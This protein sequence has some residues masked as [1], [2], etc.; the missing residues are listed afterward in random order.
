MKTIRLM[1]WNVNGLRAVHRKKALDWFLDEKP[2]ILCLQETKAAANQIPD[3][4]KNIDGYH[5]Y[6]VSAEKKGYSGVALYS[7]REPKKLSS[8]FGIEKFD[9]EGRIIIAEYDKFILFNIYYPNGKQ[10]KERLH[11][12]MEFY[13]TFLEIADRMKNGGKNLVICGDVNTAHK[14]I[15]LARPKEN[16]KVSGFLPEERAWMDKFVEHGYHDTFRMF[17]REPEQY[18]WWDMITRARERNVG[19]RIDYF[20]VSDSLKKKVRKAFIRPEIMG[21]DHCP[22]GIDLSL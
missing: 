7:R 5:T 13:D 12:K 3:E 6:F 16:E 8:G 14:E 20:F 2:D 19:W 9:N 22:I 17:N 18:T 10:S 15:D 1:S 4:L 11:Y 21:S